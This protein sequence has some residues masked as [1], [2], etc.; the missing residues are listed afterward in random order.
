[1][2]PDKNLQLWDGAVPAL[3]SVSNVIDID[4]LRNIGTGVPLYIRVN[5]NSNVRTNAAG[6]IVFY[7]TYGDDQSLTNPLYSLTFPVNVDVSTGPNAGEVVY[8][9]IPPICFGAQGTG[10]FVTPNATKKYLGV[11]FGGYGWSTSSTGTVTIDIVT[12]VNSVENIYAGGF[13]VK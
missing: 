11:V 4:T 13:S 8:L 7:V 6:A 12:E 3:G 5:F 2:I 10:K 9:P 1:M